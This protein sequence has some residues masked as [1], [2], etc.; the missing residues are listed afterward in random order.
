MAS[1][2]LI[3]DG[4]EI[5]RFI[6]SVSG[7]KAEIRA[8]CPFEPGYIYR[9][10]LARDGQTLYLGIMEPEGGRFV[11]QRSLPAKS[12][13]FLSGAGSLPVIAVSRS[14][15][16]Q[17]RAETK[18]VSDPDKTLE[19]TE[20]SAF[21]PLIERNFIADAS[22]TAKFACKDD[23]L[24]NTYNNEHFVAFPIEIGGQ[25]SFAAFFF[26]AVFRQNENGEGF[27]VLKIGSS[28][29]ICTQN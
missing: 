18:Q 8:S 28:G 27:G 1:G 5:G 4:R 26:A 9:L 14:L 7:S 6:W 16:G 20:I 17:E 25:S 19:S 22:L 24:Y 23:I 21:R 29:Y 12:I 13:S 10:S 2:V 15:P 3:L 11:L